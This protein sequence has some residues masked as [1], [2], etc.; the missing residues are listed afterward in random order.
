MRATILVFAYLIRTNEALSRT[1]RKIEWEIYYNYA[2]GK[3]AYTIRQNLLMKLAQEF[4]VNMVSGN[5]LD[6]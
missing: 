2:K 1:F 6:M 4:N 5:L 3:I